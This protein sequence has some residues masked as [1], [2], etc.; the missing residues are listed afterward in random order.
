MEY[1]YDTKHTEL[2]SQTRYKIQQILFTTRHKIYAMY[3]PNK[4]GNY[5][6]NKQMLVEYRHTPLR[7]LTR[8]NTSNNGQPVTINLNKYNNPAHEEAL[9]ET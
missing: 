3:D 9:K 5:H 7:G 4:T 2:S 6:S 8:N 1:M